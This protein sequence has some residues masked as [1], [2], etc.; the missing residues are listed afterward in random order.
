MLALGSS[1]YNFLK[2]EVCSSSDPSVVEIETCSVALTKANYT[3]I[4]K[5]PFNKFYVR[6]LME[7]GD[8]YLE[9]D[10]FKRIRRVRS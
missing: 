8:L 2:M 10:L 4:L 9:A 5:R 1:D 3:S 6:K 7:Y